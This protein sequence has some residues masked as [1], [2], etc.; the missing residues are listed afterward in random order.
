[1]AKQRDEIARLDNQWARLNKAGNEMNSTSSTVNWK[2]IGQV[3]VIGGSLVFPPVS[4]AQGIY[5]FSVA[6]GSEV[7]A[8]YIGQTGRKNGLAGRFGN[9]RNRGNRPG[10]R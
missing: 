9:Y 3:D 2:P 8:G 1:M 7:I 6:K 10:L 5:W 4:K